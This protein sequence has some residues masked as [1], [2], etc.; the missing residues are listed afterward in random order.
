M[1][2]QITEEM[3]LP[4]LRSSEDRV[5]KFDFPK[6]CNDQNQNNEPVGDVGWFL[7]QA[8]VA[9]LHLGQGQAEAGGA[10]QLPVVQKSSLSCT[11]KK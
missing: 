2:V 7:L 1:Q 9:G 6:C 3:S 10:D 11:T 8:A 5:E 4:R